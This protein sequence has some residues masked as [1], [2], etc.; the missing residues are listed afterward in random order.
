M[1]HLLSRILHCLGTLILQ[2]RR[3]GSGFSFC[4]YWYVPVPVFHMVQ[5]SQEYKVCKGVTWWVVT[6]IFITSCLN[7]L[8]SGDFSLDPILL[9]HITSFWS[10]SPCGLVSDASPIPSLLLLFLLYCCPKPYEG[11]YWAP[12]IPHPVPLSPILLPLLPLLPP[13][14]GIMH[15]THTQTPPPP[16]HTHTHTHIHT[17]YSSACANQVPVIWRFAQKWL[18]HASTCVQ[19]SLQMGLVCICVCVCMSHMPAEWVSHLS[20]LI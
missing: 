20:C 3:A 12:C 7:S 9:V 2:L 16:P 10:L 6:L 1:S 14:W 8:T 19:T 4:V 11:S 18:A 15:H 17:C 5:I 13:L